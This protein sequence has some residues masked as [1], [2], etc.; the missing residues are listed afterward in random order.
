M[1]DSQNPDKRL[2]TLNYAFDSLGEAH[3]RWKV[4]SYASGAAIAAG[5]G[6]A[7]T[8]LI[9]AI[10]GALNGWRT[11]GALA[12]VTASSLLLAL[13]SARLDTLGKLSGTVYFLRY[14]FPGYADWHKR[15][16]A[17]L[18]KQYDAKDL[19]VIA[20]DVTRLPEDGAIDMSGDV[21][22]MVVAFESALNTDESRT[23]I[24]IAPDLQWM[25]AMALGSQMY[26]D[27]DNQ[28]LDELRTDDDVSS[29]AG[30]KD[31][32]PFGW[33]ISQP[34]QLQTILGYPATAFQE[35][36]E[37]SSRVLVSANLTATVRLEEI[38]GQVRLGRPFLRDVGYRYRKWYGVGVFEAA[39]TERITVDTP[40]LPVEMEEPLVRIARSDG[41]RH[42]RVHPF[43]ATLAC[44]SALRR[45][46]HEN[47]TDTILFAAQVPKTVSL[48]IGWH[49]TR[50]SLPGERL[51]Q[52]GVN[53]KGLPIYRCPSPC[54]I[55]PWRRLVLLYFD[56]PS[57][58]F[59]ATRVHPLQPS[60]DDI[61]ARCRDEA[62]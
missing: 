54:C 56:E 24:H 36:K 58:Q 21:T 26:G 11:L 19:R 44:V 10:G 39:E 53:R 6:V 18:I 37:Q 13:A 61:R 28:H 8:E 3:Q 5:F 7:L 48:A 52:L 34:P 22:D 55:N 16:L 12:V 47:P 62:Q 42:A 46:L 49:L 33:Q 50:D 25:A 41:I 1:S 40:C 14:Q 31:L 57:R 15:E 35:I 30:K 9:A 38:D 32:V 4:V 17:K 60:M 51:P 43:E 20:R 27:W 23:G 29:N 2:K 45:A 59:L